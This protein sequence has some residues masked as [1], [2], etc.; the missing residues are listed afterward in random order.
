MVWC[1]GWVG[2]GKWFGRDSSRK[3]NVR[4]PFQLTTERGASVCVCLLPR[5][6]ETKTR[7]FESCCGTTSDIEIRTMRTG[8]IVLEYALRTGT[9]F[10]TS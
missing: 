4:D 5:K 10:A 1:L 2:L 7:N 3:R 6:R 8:T 9:V